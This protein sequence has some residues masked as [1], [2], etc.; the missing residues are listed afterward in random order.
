MGVIVFSDEPEA[1]RGD[2]LVYKVQAD[3]D[4]NGICGDSFPINTA[5]RQYFLCA[6][7]YNSFAVIIPF[8]EINLSAGLN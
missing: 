8:D 7:K 2:H 3:S 6:K 5:N 4:L 1:A